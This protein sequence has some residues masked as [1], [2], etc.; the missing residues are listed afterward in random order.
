MESYI[1][2]VFI[3][4]YIYANIHCKRGG[5][6]EMVWQGKEKYIKEWS[7]FWVVIPAC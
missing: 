1:F 6:G 3:T 4:K 2:Y 7:P 5:F